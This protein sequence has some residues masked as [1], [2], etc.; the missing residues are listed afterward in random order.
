MGKHACPTYRAVLRD[1]DQA[2][3]IAEAVMIGVPDEKPE[4]F[5]NEPRTEAVPEFSSCSDPMAAIMPF[6]EANRRV[7]PASAAAAAIQLS[8]D[9]FAN[10]SKEMGSMLSELSQCVHESE[11]QLKRINSEIELKKKELLALYDIDAAA[12][13]L[14]QLAEE[15]R[16]QKEHLERL[17][18]DQQSLWEEEKERIALDESE[19]LEDL[20]IQRR[21]EEEDFRQARD[22][23]Q[24]EIHR[25]FE[26]E[27]Q[28]V[29]QKAIARQEEKDN[30]LLQREEAL[31]EKE[32]ESALLIQ[33][34]DGF[35]SQLELRLNSAGV[36]P[37][38]TR[39]RV[40]HPKSG[41]PKPSQISFNEEESSVLMPVNEMALSLNQNDSQ[42]GSIPLK[43]ESTLLQFSFKK[44]AST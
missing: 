9:R 24:L 27:L 29:R 15:Q 21:R 5:Q 11:N 36:V 25:K 39:K 28:T 42:Q 6:Q 18:Y 3:R 22:F 44:P 26:Q 2:D 33:A 4:F 40:A 7:E 37:K 19:F 17:I 34:L 30:E 23:E 14:K 32:R 13:S 10:L 38:D 43:Q 1:G 35:L 16:V 20:R 41:S 8:M 12:I 31:I